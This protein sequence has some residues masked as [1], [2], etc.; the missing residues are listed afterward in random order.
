MFITYTQYI[1]VMVKRYNE[2]PSLDITDFSDVYM[3]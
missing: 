3:P 2:H 1:F